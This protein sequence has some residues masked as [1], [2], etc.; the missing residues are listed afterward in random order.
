[1]L[2]R[3]LVTW[4]VVVG[5]TYASSVGLAGRFAG[6]LTAEASAAASDDRSGGSSSGVINNTV[7]KSYATPALW[8]FTDDKKNDS[9]K[10]GAVTF[11]EALVATQARAKER[12]KGLQDIIFDPKKYKLPPGDR[13]AP[14]QAYEEMRQIE[15]SPRE[16]ADGFPADYRPGKGYEKK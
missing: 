16:K 14:Q 11:D 15:L 13:D 2:L 6:A 9:D 8:L 5:V 1:M 7:E 12:F 4:L 3:A 10:D